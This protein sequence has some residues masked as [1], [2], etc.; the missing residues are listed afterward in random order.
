MPDIAALEPHYRYWDNFVRLWRL[1][2]YPRAPYLPEPWWGWHPDSGEEL[3]SVVLNLNPGSGGRLQ[4]RC[5]VSCALGCP[6]SNASYSSAMNDGTLRLHLV[7]TEHWHHRRRYVPLMKALGADEKEIAPDTRHHL[8]IEL[9]PFHDDEDNRIYCCDN[10][11]GALRHALQFAARA[12]RLIAHPRCV[13]DEPASL[14]NIVIARCA[15]GKIIEIAGTEAI[16]DRTTV[17]ADAGKIK[18]ETFRLKE[19]AFS[20]VLFV[21]LS[22]ARNSLP[23]HTSLKNILKTII[24]SSY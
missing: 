23:S 7:D 10:R 21:A 19:A 11:D 3:H 12:S 5:C 14:R 15:V 22:G 24:N 20:D 9:L 8:S 2:N 16:T 1:G 4:S 18:I 17:S 6:G 13:S